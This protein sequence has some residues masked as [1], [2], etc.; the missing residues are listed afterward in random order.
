LVGRDAKPRRDAAGKNGTSIAQTLSDIE[1]VREEPSD[2]AKNLRE[3]VVKVGSHRAALFADRR[4]RWTAW[5]VQRYPEED[6]DMA[7]AYTES[8]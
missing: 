8:S 5:A 1:A 2:V 7:K 6:R 3:K 4:V